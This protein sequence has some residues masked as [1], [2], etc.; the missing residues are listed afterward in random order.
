MVDTLYSSNLTHHDNEVCNLLHSASHTLLS[1]LMKYYN[2]YD[3]YR[4]VSESSNNL[5]FHNEYGLSLKVPKEWNVFGVIDL[6]IDKLQ[7][8]HNSAILIIYSN[9]A[10]YKTLLSVAGDRAS[11]ISWHEIFTA[12]QLVHT[13]ASQIKYVRSVIS[14]SDVVLF[15]SPPYHINEVIEQVRAFTDGCLILI[16]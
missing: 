13:D 8:E 5:Q 12:R 9:S 15:M 14:A 1:L 7:R 6:F 11:Y 16:D 4:E 3:G 2:D 10:S